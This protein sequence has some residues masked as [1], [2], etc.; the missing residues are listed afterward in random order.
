MNLRI[1]V[2]M[3]SYADHLLFG[4]LA[5]YETV[6]DVDGL[7]RDIEVAVS[8]LAAISARRKPARDRRLS[9]VV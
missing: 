8:R 3:L 5:D 1:G 9:L 2:A 6:P 7:A 4:I